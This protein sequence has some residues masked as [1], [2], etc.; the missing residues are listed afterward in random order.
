MYLLF[1]FRAI[2][3]LQKDLAESEGVDLGQASL[4]SQQ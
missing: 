4:T 2:V 3:G 1:M